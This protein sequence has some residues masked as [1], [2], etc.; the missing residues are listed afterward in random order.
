[1]TNSKQT[2]ESLI[3]EHAEHTPDKI[4]VIDENGNSISYSA[5]WNHILNAAGSLLGLGLKKGDRIVLAA[6]KSV[7]FIYLY[8][9]THLIGAVAVPVDPE[10]NA[11]RLDRIVN[12]TEPRIIIGELRNAGELKVTSFKDIMTTENEKG[13]DNLILP[14]SHNIADILFTTGTTGI[15]K[16]VVLTNGNELQAAE[17]INTFIGNTSDDTEILALP[18]SHSFGLGRIRCVLSKGATLVI[19]GSFASMKKFFGAIEKYKA[20]GFGMVPASWAYIA[21]MSGDKLGGF[22]KQLKYI[23]I[24]SAPMPLA[25][26]RRL[27]ALLPD[28]KI[29]MHY[30]LT[31]ASRSAFIS[32]H[33]ESEHLETA[34][35]ASPNC[36]IAVFDADGNR[37]NANCD[38][39][40]CVKGDHVCSSYWQNDETYRNDFF[41]GYFRTGDWGCID[42]EGYLHLK[43]RT[44]EIINVGGKKVSPME[45]EE[46]LESIE[47]VAEAACI[48]VPDPV[49][50][51]VV[52]AFVTS[53][54]DQDK[55]KE[56]IKTMSTLVENYKVPV[57]VRHV[58]SLPRTSSGK[59]QR[60][61]L[62]E[63]FYG[64]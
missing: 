54:I 30:G 57:S 14:L 27:M 4:A 5:L 32:F 18:V 6:S 64:R 48:G 31:E 15:P 53:L 2:I 17:N 40:V 42:D 52:V 22:A 39:E 50:G 36:D 47:G 10:V 7:D 29:C 28:T 1:M 44:K 49:M 33:E 45:V 43:S 3:R 19:A 59:L 24:G 63:E 56:I 34:G 61:K 16:G 38:G 37:L 25:E 60:L 13:K 46:A 23:E 41:D 35:K 8:F 51:E 12:I 58:D 20:T 26:K 55:E 21:K 9:A 62:K 11:S